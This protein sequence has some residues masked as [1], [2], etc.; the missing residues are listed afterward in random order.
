MSILSPFYSISQAAG[1]AVDIRQD[2][3]YLINC[4]QVITD[5]KQLT[6][7]KK[8]TDLDNAD[9]LGGQLNPK[10]PVTL[11]L[12][13]KGVLIKQ[14]GGVNEVQQDPDKIFP[15]LNTADFYLQQF[16]S[17]DQLFVSVIRKNVADHWIG[18]L[19]Q[20]G[21]S[22][23]S[24]SLG[25]FPLSNVMDQLNIYEGDINLNGFRIKR[26]EQMNWTALEYSPQYISP[27]AL[28]MGSEPVGQ[29]LI[30]PYATAFQLVLF[31]NLSPVQAI[32]ERLDLQYN[33]VIDI[34]KL[35]MTGALILGFFFIFLL[36][37]VIVLS[38]LNAENSLLD[39]KVSVSANSNSDM[40]ALTAQIKA[41]EMLLDDIG[42]DGAINKARFIDQ[43]AA[44]LP[45][46][47]TLGD[48]AINPLDNANNKDTRQLHFSDHR[49]RLSGSSQQVVA[50]NEW[51]ARIKTLKW[52]KS[53]ELE[54][55]DYDSDQ[56]TGKFNIIIRY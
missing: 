23:L 28:K 38:W 41:K 21:Y 26:D 29:Q 9:A 7:E 13:G 39:S 31:S 34:K 11:N 56:Q 17:G 19:E 22:V 53:A 33:K 20:L 30:L 50:V 24:L 54:S 4:C 51:V 27:F 15:D 3:S 52:V 48:M 32:V 16:L 6:I 1:I 18:I 49:I 8:I 2:G 55:F 36:L 14:I 47:I 25:P 46:E 40:E 43:L 42:W 5:R 35:K 37:N 45:E 10:I 44:L 12:S